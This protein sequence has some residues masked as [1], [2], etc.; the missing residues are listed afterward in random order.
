M[1]N[2]APEP[3]TPN[4]CLNSGR[5]KAAQ[6]SDKHT[7][8]AWQRHQPGGIPKLHREPAEATTKTL[9]RRAPWENPNRWILSYGQPP[10]SDRAASAIFKLQVV[11]ARLSSR[12]RSPCLGCGIRL[13][14]AGFSDA[15]LEICL[16]HTLNHCASPVI[17]GSILEW[18]ELRYTNGLNGSLFVRRARCGVAPAVRTIARNDTQGCTHTHRS[19]LFWV[20]C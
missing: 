12:R 4:P 1:L 19:A 5:R 11:L 9:E 17:G 10:F 7:L 20:G 8:Q 15:G 18:G 13:R 3:K 16:G 14:C 6:M 2:P